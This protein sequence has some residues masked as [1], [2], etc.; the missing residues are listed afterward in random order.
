[1]HIMINF[2]SQSHH[3]V[4]GDSSIQAGQLKH[5]YK[6][7]SL[8]SIGSKHNYLPWIIL[9]RDDIPSCPLSGLDQNTITSLELSWIGMI[10]LHARS[11]GLDQNTITS[12]ELSWIGMIFLHA[13]S[14][15]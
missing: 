4:H 14:P 12:L 9:D 2:V 10:F 1:M 15:V 11:S 3:L 5:S 6:S 8:L 13:R 7:K